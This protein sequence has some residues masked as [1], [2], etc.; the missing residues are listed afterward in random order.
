MG[1][2]TPAQIALLKTVRKKAWNQAF[3]VFTQTIT[4]PGTDYYDEPGISS[5][6]QVM[7]GDWVWRDQEENRGEAGGVI[8]HSDVRLATDIINSGALVAPGA[9]L[10]VDGITCA[11]VKASPDPLGIEM[12]VSAVRVNAVP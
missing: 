5:G 4:A 8:E 2:L 10:I 7:S 11:I 9:R 12:L 3:T 6:T 1:F